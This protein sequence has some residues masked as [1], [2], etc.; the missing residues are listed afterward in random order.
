M[1]VEEIKP[2]LWLAG[3]YLLV[4]LLLTIVFILASKFSCAI[5]SFF[6]QFKV[7]K[8]HKYSLKPQKS[9][10]P[11]NFKLYYD[12]APLKISV[13][14]LIDDCVSVYQSTSYRLQKNQLYK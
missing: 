7:Q 6:V 10:L 1:N 12:E 11:A 2:F 8:T 5:F 3:F 13:Q 4:S 9:E 14:N